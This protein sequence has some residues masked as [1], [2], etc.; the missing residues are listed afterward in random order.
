MSVF[1]YEYEGDGESE[2]HSPCECTA[3]DD[4]AFGRV[5]GAARVVAMAGTAGAETA[6][7]RYSAAGLY[8]PLR[9]AKTI[10]V[11]RGDGSSAA[12]S[13]SP[14]DNVRL[15]LLQGSPDTGIERAT[16]EL[17]DRLRRADGVT[18]LGRYSTT[19]DVSEIPD[20]DFAIVI[21]GDGSILRGCRQLGMR[22]VPMIGVNLGRLGF[23]ADLSPDDLMENLGALQSRD[24]CV[25]SHL[26][27]QCE[28]HVSD[29]R[30]LKDHGLNEVC[31]TSGGSLK[32]VDIA[33][34]I[35]GEHVT[36]F[37]CDG[38][39]VSTPVGST[40]HN[41]SAGGP[42]LRQELQ[43][44]VITP[45]C[46]HTLTVRPI[47]DSAERTYALACS[48]APDGVMLSI[49]GQIQ[50]AFTST[51][52]IVIRKSDATFQ[53]VRFQ[54]HSYYGT[55]HRKLGWRGQL[56]YRERRGRGEASGTAADD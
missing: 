48:E 13:A 23:L 31:I 22:Q 20:V 40:A 39:I 32:M 15:L 43:V 10:C 53:L 18:V 26:M 42:I 4:P 25:A 2:H 49:D 14:N 6:W 27:F 24:F 51:D 1:E 38:L 16:A 50:R 54:G 33:L 45:I 36:T 9:V 41:L 28:H 55:L 21:G 3:F 56:D 37:S 7:R 5:S 52:R 35:D 12:M 17:D 30:V 44:F 11:L 34:E 19:D 29:G 8:N 47:V 46:P